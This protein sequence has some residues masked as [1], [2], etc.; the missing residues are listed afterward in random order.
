MKPVKLTFDLQEDRLVD[1][2][3]I[4]DFINNLSSPIKKQDIIKMVKT[5]NQKSDIHIYLNEYNETE[6][7]TLIEFI[8]K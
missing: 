4:G 1:V 2:T 3:N 7:H 6:N 5:F 8:I